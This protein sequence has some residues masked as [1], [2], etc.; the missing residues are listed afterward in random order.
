M[1]K[2]SGRGDGGDHCCYINGVV[3]EFLTYEDD[4]P[5]C[6]LR[7]EHGNWHAVHAD[8]RWKNAPVGR[9][10]AA[11]HPGFGCGDWPDKIPAA[12]EQ[13]GGKCCWQN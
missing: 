3:C 13:P 2:C 11:R 4:L 5:R 9:W 12:I 6:G 1:A 7:L 10:F 8:L